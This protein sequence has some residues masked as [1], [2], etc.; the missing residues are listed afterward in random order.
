MENKLKYF[1]ECVNESME[2]EPEQMEILSQCFSNAMK[3]QKYIK[4]RL[5]G[6]NMYVK[7]KLGSF[8]GDKKYITDR[9]YAISD[10]WKQLSPEEYQRYDKLAELE[11]IKRSRNVNVPDY[12]D[13]VDI[14]VDIP[15]TPRQVHEQS[16][17]KKQSTQKKQSVQ[18]KQS[19]QK[20]QSV[21]K[22]QST[23]KKQLG[24]RSENY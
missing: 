18:K 14:D 2:V 9:M 16:A 3:S 4:Q 7:E 20:K 1:R 24:Q 11:T 21:Q 22:K 5:S 15:S 17:Q 10:S 6:W 23:Q 12:S 13:V 19:T 8:K